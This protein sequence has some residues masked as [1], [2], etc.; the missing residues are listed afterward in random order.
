MRIT[1]TGLA[2]EYRKKV[3]QAFLKTAQPYV[4]GED[5]EFVHALVPARNREDI[6][7]R[8]ENAKYVASRRLEGM[9]KEDLNRTLK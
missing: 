4:N 7:I 1:L 9:L 6:E 2:E 5:V 8:V 3:E